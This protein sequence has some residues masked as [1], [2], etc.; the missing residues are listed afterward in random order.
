MT[1][2]WV[3]FAFQI[4]NVVIL[5]AILRHFLFRPVAE[6][7]ARRQAETE[8]TLAA[9][10]TAQDTAQ[11]AI[12]KARAEAAETEK[13]R[14]DVLLA[15]QTEAETQR[16]AL[17]E[18]AQAEA[19]RIL[20]EGRATLARQQGADQTHELTLARDLALRIARRALTAQPSGLSGYAARL[21]A[22]LAALSETERRALLQGGNLRLLSPAPLSAEDLA[23]ARAALAPFDIAPPPATDPALIAGLELHSDAGAVRNSL[24]HDLDQI[25]KAMRD[26]RT[27]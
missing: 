21:A 10:R 5:L 13:A 23:L 20:A 19:A 27:A 14:H 26:D 12:A 3:T 17:L 4:V 2:D 25:A 8:A 11:A 9:A 18:A 16:K 22:A 1:F 6:V 7:I 24:S 15:A